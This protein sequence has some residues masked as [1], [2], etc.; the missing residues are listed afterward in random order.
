MYGA[1]DIGSEQTKC[2]TF[3]F[4]KSTLATFIFFKKQTWI[5]KRYLEIKNLLNSDFQSSE[6]NS[7]K[8]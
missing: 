4:P 2:L 1:N 5:D 8:I 7:N 3:S 6:K